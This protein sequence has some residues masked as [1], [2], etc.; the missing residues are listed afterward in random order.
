MKIFLL[1]IILFFLEAFGSFICF[2][3][4]FNL[5][6]FYLF[7]ASIESLIVFYLFSKTDD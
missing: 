3:I 5:S 4:N 7:I 1:L 2:S 6:G